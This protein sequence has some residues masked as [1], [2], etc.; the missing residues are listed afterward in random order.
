MPTGLR[1]SSLGQQCLHVSI[2]DE[3]LLRLRPQRNEIIVES[4]FRTE[5]P[6]RSRYGIARSRKSRAKGER[7]ASAEIRRPVRRCQC[8]RSSR[9]TSR[10]A[11]NCGSG[12]IAKLPSGRGQCELPGTRAKAI[13][14]GCTMCGTAPTARDH[15]TNLAMASRVSMLR[16]KT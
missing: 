3:F 7:C 14:E 8:R 6:Y 12:L 9:R 4:T 11:G 16:E 15:A 13:S 10:L 1:W 5:H 2:R